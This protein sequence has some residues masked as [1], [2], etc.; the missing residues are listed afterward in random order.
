MNASKSSQITKKKSLLTKENRTGK[1]IFRPIL[2]L[3]INRQRA[4]FQPPFAT[5]LARESISVGRWP[6]ATAARSTPAVA[7]AISFVGGMHLPVKI[8]HST[9]G[10]DG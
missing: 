3:S 7:V 6:R 2:R 9:W 1:V 4:V 5:D 10:L 8:P